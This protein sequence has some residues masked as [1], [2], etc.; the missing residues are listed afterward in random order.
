[1]SRLTGQESL[2]LNAENEFA[3]LLRALEQTFSKLKATP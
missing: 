3:E 1:V 2:I